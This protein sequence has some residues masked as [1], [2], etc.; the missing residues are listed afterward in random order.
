L[1]DLEEYMKNAGFASQEHSK[2]AA[3]TGRPAGWDWEALA[4]AAGSWAVAGPNVTDEALAAFMVGEAKR[5]A[6]AKQPP[7]VPYCKDK[8]RAWRR[9]LGRDP[10]QSGRQPLDEPLAG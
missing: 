1:P 8:I 9:S 2:T 10:D 4:F 5:L 7:S 3:R 6:P